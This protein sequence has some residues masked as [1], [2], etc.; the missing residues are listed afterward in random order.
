MAFYIVSFE[1]RKIKE[2][3]NKF[4]KIETFTKCPYLT[5]KLSHRRSWIQVFLLQHSFYTS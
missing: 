3:M 2:S 5:A 1:E 4:R